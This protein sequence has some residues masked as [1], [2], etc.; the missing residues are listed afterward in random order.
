MMFASIA[1]AVEL[2]ATL[3]WSGHQRYGFTVN[4]VVDGSVINVG[5]KIEKGDMLA[6]L[7]R[8]PYNFRVKQ[9]QAAVNKFKPL[10]FDA[11]LEFDHANELFERTVLSE[12]ELQKIEGKY[13]AVIAEQEE[14]QAKLQL[15]KW[16]LRRASLK[17]KDNGFVVFSNISPGMIISDE[18]KSSVYIELVSA[19]KA[20]ANA[21]LSAEQ[22]LQLK[23]DSRPEVEVDGETAQGTIHSVAMLPNKDN[24]YQLIV[25][26]NYSKMIEPGKKVRVR[27]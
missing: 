19:S 25:D 6:S 27:F 12:V 17:S 23:L 3:N 7:D 14:E 2:D 10:V 11:K 22:K 13:R 26:F 1:Q 20:S 21:W 18:N 5:A 15:A 4:G 9:Y 24:K 8:Q 16:K